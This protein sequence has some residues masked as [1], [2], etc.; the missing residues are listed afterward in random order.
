MLHDPSCITKMIPCS[1]SASLQSPCKSK[2]KC[3][4]LQDW[5]ASIVFQSTVVRSHYASLSNQFSEPYRI[6]TWAHTLSLM[7]PHVPQ[8]FTLPPASLKSFEVHGHSAALK[9]SSLPNC[10]VRSQS[11]GLKFAFKCARTS[12]RQAFFRVCTKQFLSPLDKRSI[13]YREYP[14]KESAGTSRGATRPAGYC[15]RVP[16]TRGA[17]CIYIYIYI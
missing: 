17:I 13:F 15:R 3:F 2:R 11:Q 12:S 5:I 7:A 14:T 1:S 10:E 9:L 8:R 16:S 6:L 4:H